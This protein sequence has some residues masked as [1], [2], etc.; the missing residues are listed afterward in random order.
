[1]QTQEYEPKTQPT[2]TKTQHIKKMRT[3]V[4]SLTGVL[5]LFAITFPVA[6]WRVSQSDQYEGLPVKSLTSED[7][8][9]PQSS[10]PD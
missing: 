7:T 6:C 9:R 5:I 2:E 3:Y 10:Y 1:M 4:L 8:Q